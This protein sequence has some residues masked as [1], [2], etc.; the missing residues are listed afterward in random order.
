MTAVWCRHSAKARVLVRELV[1]VAGLE[2]CAAS[3]GTRSEVAECRPS[4]RLRFM[5]ISEFG[6]FFPIHGERSLERQ[7]GLRRQL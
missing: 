3:M 2:M 4:H 7:A 5:E 6:A 1:L